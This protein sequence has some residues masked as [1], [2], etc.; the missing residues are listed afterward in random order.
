[1]EFTCTYVNSGGYPS[2]QHL[3]NEKFE[4]MLATGEVPEDV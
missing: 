1:M 4:T 2:T 3:S